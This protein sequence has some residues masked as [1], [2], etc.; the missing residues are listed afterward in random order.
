MKFQE[1]PSLGSRAV[2][3]RQIKGQ[4]DRQ[5]DKTKIVST[6]A[7]ALR[8]RLFNLMMK[9]QPATWTTTV[10]LW[11]LILRSQRLT[12]DVSENI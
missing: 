6:F 1:N 2:P 7:V 5:T 10:V 8:K 4:T 3:C 11:G 9:F 12:P